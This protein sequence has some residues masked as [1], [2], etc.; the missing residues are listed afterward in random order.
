[1]PLLCRPFPSLSLSRPNPRL[2][3]RPELMTIATMTPANY[4]QHAICTGP[5]TPFWPLLPS[6]RG[7]S[8]CGGCCCCCGCYST[9]N[10]AQ[11]SDCGANPPI[12]SPLDYVIAAKSRS[13]HIQKERERGG[14]QISFEAREFHSHFARNNHS[15]GT[16][17]QT[18]L[19]TP[20]NNGPSPARPL[21]HSPRR[22]EFF[23]QI[24]SRVGAVIE[25]AL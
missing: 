8:G 11:Q 7:F 21:A 15:N 12:N 20:C 10:A 22:I 1:M 18:A 14:P 23:L 4:C 24:E 13:S 17:S 2:V 16:A 25:R 19:T 6:S 3:S 5:K 9:T